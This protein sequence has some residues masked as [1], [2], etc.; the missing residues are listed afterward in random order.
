MADK[1]IVLKNANV[2]RADGLEALSIPIVTTDIA[3]L[4]IKDVQLEITSLTTGDNGFY[5]YPSTLQVDGVKQGPPV[6]LSGTNSPSTPM[7]LTGSQIVEPNSVV[8][9][10]V[11][12][13]TAKT[14]FGNAQVIYV[15]GTDSSPT[16]GTL[17]MGSKSP[18]ATGQAGILNSL[19]GSGKPAGSTDNGYS[20]C[21][22]TSNG[23]KKY[24]YT[25]G[26]NLMIL[27]ED[28]STLIQHSWGYNCYGMGVDDTYCYGKTSGTQ[29]YLMRFNHI[30]MV[31]ADNLTISQS[32][33]YGSSNPG[34]VD[35]YKGHFYYRPSG[36]STG[37]KKINLITGTNTNITMGSLAQTEML[38]GVINTNVNGANLLVMHQDQTLQVYDI[39]K[40]SEANKSSIFPTNPTTTNGNHVISLAAGIV[41]VNNPSYNASMIINTNAIKPT[42]SSPKNFTQTLTTGVI[43]LGGSTQDAFVGGKHQSTAAKTR[44]MNYRVLASGVEVT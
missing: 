24:S 35:V 20:G 17:S 34:W 33:S 44:K 42:D 16:V 15:K 21:C 29:T 2:T 39:D 30:T 19:I 6:H 25:D 28:G 43:S 8:T 10:E 11:E 37:V 18:E 1:L 27:G 38:G 9:L 7:L 32:Y 23:I 40:G 41:W 14:D 13:E 22:F 31:A 26:S 36:S 3:Q 4:A 5:K 12:A